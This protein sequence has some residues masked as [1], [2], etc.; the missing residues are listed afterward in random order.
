MV[1]RP[2]CTVVKKTKSDILWKNPLSTSVTRGQCYNFKNVIDEKMGDFL[3][4]C[5]TLG[6]K[7]WSLTFL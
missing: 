4:N 3:S 2:T 7:K 6:G 1:V 5:R